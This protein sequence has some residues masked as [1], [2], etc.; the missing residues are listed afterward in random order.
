MS[1]EVKAFSCPPSAAMR[2]ENFALRHG[3]VPLEH[4][5]LEHMGHADSR[6]VSSAPT[7]SHSIYRRGRAPVGLHDDGHAIGQLKGLRA[8]PPWP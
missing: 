1:R 5:V 2:R 3:G 7:R 6:S 8:T 4:H